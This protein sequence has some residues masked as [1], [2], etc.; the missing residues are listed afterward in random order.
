MITLRDLSSI[1]FHAHHGDGELMR[2]CQ[3]CRR[4]LPVSEFVGC[5]CSVCNDV[6]IA[7]IA[8]E[9]R[10]RMLQYWRDRYQRNKLMR[11]NNEI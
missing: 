9:K 3:P 7:R 11:I 8:A 1:T 5:L 10:E 2:I 4:I 6:E